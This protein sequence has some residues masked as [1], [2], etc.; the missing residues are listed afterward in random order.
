MCFLVSDWLVVSL[1]VLFRRLHRRAPAR[2]RRKAAGRICS[3]TALSRRRGSVSLTV[4]FRRLHRPAPARARRKAAGRICSPTALSRRRGS[5]SL[6]VLF[7]RLHRRAPA[8]ARRKAAGRI[9]SPTALSRRRGDD[10]AIAG[11]A[12]TTQI[13]NSGGAERAAITL[14]EG[15]EL[16]AGSCISRPDEHRRIAPAHQDGLTA[17]QA[18]GVGG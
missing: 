8:R 6:T 3:P 13:E 10:G 12:L 5:V 17:D 15:D 4:L 16:A 2:A 11:G 1:T 9:C 18:G 7:R 14:D